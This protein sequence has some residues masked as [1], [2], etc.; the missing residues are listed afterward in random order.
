M[1]RVRGETDGTTNRPVEI[2]GYYRQSLL[3]RD[4]L[5]GRARGRLAFSELKFR[6]HDNANRL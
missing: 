1:L 3:N 5:P 4:Q 2:A 6:N